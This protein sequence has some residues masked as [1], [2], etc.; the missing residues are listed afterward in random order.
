LGDQ[1]PGELF[2]GVPFLKVG[3]TSP[4]QLITVYQE[5]KKIFQID[6]EMLKEAWKQPMQKVFG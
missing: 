2:T 6:L 1:E 3:V 4:E 5:E